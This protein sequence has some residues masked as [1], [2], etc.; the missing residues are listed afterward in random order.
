MPARALPGK[1]LWTAKQMS[2]RCGQTLCSS[3]VLKACAARISVHICLLHGFCSSSTAKQKHIPSKG[4]GCLASLAI[5]SCCG[6]T[7][8][9]FRNTVYVF[10]PIKKNKNL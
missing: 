2:S 5:M 10:P 7:Y 8:G 1:R 6:S 4:R 3:F 9:R